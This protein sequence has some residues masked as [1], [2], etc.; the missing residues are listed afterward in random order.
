[1]A[2]SSLDSTEA[3]R[4]AYMRRDG[5]PYWVESALAA[6][7]RKEREGTLHFFRR[8]HGFFFSGRPSTG[9]WQ[10]IL[11]CEMFWTH[12]HVGSCRKVRT[13]T[14]RIARIQAARGPSELLRKERLTRPSS[15]ASKNAISRSEIYCSKLEKKTK[16]LLEMLSV[17][18]FVDYKRPFACRTRARMQVTYTLHGRLWCKRWHCQRMFT[19]IYNLPRIVASTLLCKRSIAGYLCTSFIAN[20]TEWLLQFMCK[21]VFVFLLC[22]LFVHCIR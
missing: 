12:R 16:K 21:Y 9:E 7:E 11:I 1:M 13:I 17:Q 4:A 6:A 10:K 3:A 5:L 19:H 18:P 14:C 20:W 15:S 2:D 22:W 8:R